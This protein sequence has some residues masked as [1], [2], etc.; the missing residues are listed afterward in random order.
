MPIRIPFYNYKLPKKVGRDHKPTTCVFFIHG[1]GGSDASWYRFTECLEDQ[2]ALADSFGLEYDDYYDTSSKF[3]RVPIIS[4]FLM[5]LKIFTGVSIDDLARVLDTKLKTFGHE[6]QNIIIVSHSMGG[7]VARKHIIDVVEKNKSTGKIKALI[8]YATPHNGSVW[9]NWYIKAYRHLLGYF[10]K[11]SLQISQLSPESKFLDE[12]NKKWSRLNIDDKI[13]YYRIYGLS[14]WVVNRKSA[15]HDEN[16]SKSMPVNKGHLSI[17]KPKDRKKDEA[18]LYTYNY[19]DKFYENQQNKL[20]LADL[21][22]EE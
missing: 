20:E 3:H 14:D 7:L 4:N 2:Y 13:E 8:T 21:S 16:D 22:L 11:N 19:L 9:A 17:I 10:I 12:L 6:Y 18:F 15:S 1:L 5:I